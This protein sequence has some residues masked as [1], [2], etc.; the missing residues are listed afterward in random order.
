MF[1]TEKLTMS[2]S[3]SNNLQVVACWSKAGIGT[4]IVLDYKIQQPQP[5]EA[6]ISCSSSRGCRLVL[7][8]GATPCF[9]EAITAD[10]VL[11]SHGHL[12][13]IG[14]IFSHARA[15]SCQRR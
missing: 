13:H 14:A 7:D 8:L 15:V 9:A 5:R 11:I 2:L 4:C 10:V 1:K 12:D 6:A 3:T